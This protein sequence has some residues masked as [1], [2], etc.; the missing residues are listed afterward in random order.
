MALFE[1]N[2]NPSDRDLKWAAGI[3]W[4]FGLCLAGIAWWKG[5]ALLGLALALTVAWLIS[6]VFNSEK[7]GQQLLGVVLPGMM[8]AI[9]GAVRAGADPGTVA[10]VVG[11]IGTVIAAAMFASPAVGRAVYVGWLLAA[12]PIGWTISHLVLG[13]VYYLVITP[14]SLLMRLTGRDPLHRKLDRE[15]DTY[16][17]EHNPASDPARYFRQF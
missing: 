10:V 11:G 13:A 14:L 16:W 15:A 12:V 9:G 17:I 7:R 2:T 6:Q 4:L 8:A 3:L 5:A 1:V